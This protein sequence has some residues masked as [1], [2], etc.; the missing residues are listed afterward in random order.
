MTVK[1]IHC[2]NK[3]ATV[4]SKI[5]RKRICSTTDE[6]DQLD[7]SS[8]A[9]K[10][11]NIKFEKIIFEVGIRTYG[12]RDRT[13]VT[14]NWAPLLNDVLW[15]ELRLPCVWSFKRARHRINDIFCEGNCSVCNA[16][17]SVTCNH[18]CNE[19]QVVIKNYHEETVHPPNKKRRMR[20][21]KRAEISD[22]LEK[23]SSYS[24]RSKLANELMN[25]GDREPPH[26]PTLNTMRIIKHES[27]VKE[28]LNENPIQSIND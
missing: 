3:G 14:N 24:V 8:S 11:H 1:K 27:N 7:K 25:F 5:N 26:L 23:D 12:D 9:E 4:P 19:L 21:A 28:A 22:M 10:R 20:K 2:E 16:H 18:G 6:D 13:V 17:L 15:E